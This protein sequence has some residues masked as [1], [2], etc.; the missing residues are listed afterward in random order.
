[1]ATLVAPPG[2]EEQWEENLN[3]HMT[4]PDCQIFPANLVEEFASGDM[5]CGDCGLV[6]GGRIVDTRSEWRTF[7]NDDQANDDPSR[8]GDGPNLLLNGDQLSTE[9][10]HDGVKSRDLLRAQGKSTGDK[11]NKTLL[12]AYK[13]IGA[14]SASIHLSQIVI[15]T[16]KHMFKQI[17]DE[18]FLRGKTQEALIAGCLIV[19][20]R[21]CNSPRTFREI[22][23]VTRVPKKE[24]GR[25]FK[26]LEKWFKEREAQN[27][28]CS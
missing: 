21:Y 11:G 4:C 1:M 19:A 13:Q 15:D 26:S 25:V 16:A 3:M 5:V 8:V 9:I 18:G 27:R 6:L 22:H 12:A 17:H 28:M 20:A 24:I 23:A 7:S 10:A 2:K 14:M